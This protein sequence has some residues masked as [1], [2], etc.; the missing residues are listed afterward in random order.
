MRV[1]ENKE[2]VLKEILM[3]TVKVVNVLINTKKTK[4]Q[5]FKKK[6][7]LVREISTRRVACSENSLTLAQLSSGIC[8]RRIRA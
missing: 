1:L 2:I 3:N 6:Y 4:E 7:P 8:T 5:L